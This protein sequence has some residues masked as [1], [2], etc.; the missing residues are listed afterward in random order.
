MSFT[1]YDRSVRA[2]FVGLGIYD[3]NVRASHSGST[4][5]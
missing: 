3:L 2:A 4:C 1:L 5:T